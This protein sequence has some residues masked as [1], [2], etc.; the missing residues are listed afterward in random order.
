MRKL[1]LALAAAAATF[2]LAMISTN[3]ASAR[4]G[5]GWRGHHGHHFARH[6][7]RGHHWGHRHRGW[8]GPALGF[9]AAPVYGAVACEWARVRTPWGPRW[10]RVCL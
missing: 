8:S 10:R 3:E 9:Y 4:P 5:H 1:S 2:G 6:H 7:W